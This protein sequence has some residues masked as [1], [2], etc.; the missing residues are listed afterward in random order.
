[1]WATLRVMDSAGA[2]VQNRREDFFVFTEARRPVEAVYISPFWANQPLRSRYLAD[3]DFAWGRFYLDVMLRSNLPSGFPLKNVLGG[4]Y[5]TAG[6]FL[7]G[8]QDWW[9]KKER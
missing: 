9:S 5:M 2:N 1:V 3:P 6:H 4:P 7:L 8:A